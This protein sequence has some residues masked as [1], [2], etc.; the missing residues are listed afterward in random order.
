MTGKEFK[1]VLDIIECEGF[2]YAFESY[3]D[4]SE[5]EDT[6]FHIYRLNYL[7]AVKALKEYIGY[8]V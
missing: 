5:I 8:E 3:S 4:F 6:K 7:K 1:K 2:N